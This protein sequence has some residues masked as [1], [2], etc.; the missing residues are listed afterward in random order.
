MSEKN[1]GII[2]DASNS[3]NGYNHQGKVWLVNKFLFVIRKAAK[4]YTFMQKMT[5]MWTRM[6]F[7][8]TFLRNSKIFNI[9]FASTF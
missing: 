8:S 7:S 9:K 2:F 3:W 6:G 4:W 5:L 1:P